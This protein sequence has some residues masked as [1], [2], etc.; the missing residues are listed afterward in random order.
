MVDN[1]YQNND[2]INLFS[3]TEQVEEL[4]EYLNNNLKK[5][6]TIKMEDIE[7]LIQNDNQLESVKRLMFLGDGNSTPIDKLGSG[8]QYANIIPFNVISDIIKHSRYK[9]TFPKMVKYDSE[10]KK[11]IE[12]VM[13]L[14][15]PEIHLHPH[16]Q[17]N[18]MNYLISIFSGENEEIN[19]LLKELLDIDYLKGQIVVATHSPNIILDD[20]KTVTRM[21][22]SNNELTVK[23]GEA[24]DFEKDNEK[25]FLYKFMPF[26]KNGFFSKVII[27]VE[28]DSELLALQ[29]FSGKMN[30][31]LN[32]NEIEVVSADGKGSI[33]TLSE[34]FRKFGVKTV[35]LF[36]RDQTNNENTNYNH[37]PDSF[38][39]EQE[40]FED[41][42]ISTMSGFEY[43][44][45]VLELG[46][47]HKKGLFTEIDLKSDK[48]KCIQEQS[49]NLDDFVTKVIDFY[50]S[51]EL[52]DDDLDKLLEDNIDN[53][54][55]LAKKQK[56][57]ITGQ[58]LA[59][60]VDEVP[61]VFRSVIKKAVEL[62]N[63]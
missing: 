8:I 19:S 13:G 28:G 24:I 36:D 11:Y 55:K 4:L 31:D 56:S 40:E 34:L 39:T 54:T 42:I 46:S 43:L 47:A 17:R 26:I 12:Y 18:L 23:S 25:K 10:N 53:F 21:F 61:R 41:E 58:L 51:K 57:V 52:L 1:F 38:F 49:R 6:K 37:L 2:Q 3:S 14:D 44:S 20:Y 45:F 15:E 16:L 30:V 29:E 48:L 9:K 35:A 32:L 60:H 63:E 50:S 22:H 27:L 33:P 62:S 59:Y 5:I 7:L